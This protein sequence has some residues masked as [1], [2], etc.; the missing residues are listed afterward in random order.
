MK[1]QRHAF[2]K[3]ALIMF[4]FTH[5]RERE[6][7]SGTHLHTKNRTSVLLKCVSVVMITSTY[8]STL[9]LCASI[10]QSLPR[11][12]GGS[13]HRHSCFR[14]ERCN[15]EKTEENINDRL[16]VL[17]FK[18]LHQSIRQIFLR[19]PQNICGKSQKIMFTSKYY[20]STYS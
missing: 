5:Q 4:K 7:S 19:G 3:R 15:L 9:R 17:S 16:T 11:A 18:E 20:V 2:I 14:S 8:L 1:T 6:G 10:L 12:L 13:R